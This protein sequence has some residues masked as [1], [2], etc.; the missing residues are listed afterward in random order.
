MSIKEIDKL[1]KS[2]EAE[3]D[4]LDERLK[5]FKSF[6]REVHRITVM[7]AFLRGQRH[8]LYVLLEG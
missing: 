4:Q 3:L 8:I 2:I 1:I 7:H 5:K 6:N